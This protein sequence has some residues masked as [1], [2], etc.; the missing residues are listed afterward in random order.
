MIIGVDI[1]EVLLPLVPE[2]AAW[3]NANFGTH[4][5]VDDFTT[6]RFWEAWGGT[7]EQAIHKYF[8]FV[9]SD[10]SENLAPIPN[11]VEVL[12]RLKNAGNVLFIVTSRQDEIMPVT[13]TRIER[14]FPQIFSGIFNVNHFSVSGISTSKAEICAKLWAQVMI[15]DSILY[16]QE[17][18]PS[19]GL[20][21]LFGFYPWNCERRH[22]D[23][24]RG[25]GWL[26]VEQIIARAL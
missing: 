20:P 19:V 25:F 12:E 10:W 21:I 22:A 23:L 7:R 6:Y 13:I 24:I 5:T 18:F 1:D 9:F 16:L 15:D 26:N 11:S 2:M 17:C 14:H 4:L 3:H 8:D